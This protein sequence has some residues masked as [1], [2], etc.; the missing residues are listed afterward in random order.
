MNWIKGRCMRKRIQ[1]IVVKTAEEKILHYKCKGMNKYLSGDYFDALKN[2][3]KVLL[4]SRSLMLY[5]GL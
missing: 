1:S 4:N 2:F 3:S 5:V